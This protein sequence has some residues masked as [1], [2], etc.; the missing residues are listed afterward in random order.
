MI[1]TSEIR[2]LEQRLGREFRYAAQQALNDA[3]FEVRSGLGRGADKSFSGGA[4]RFTQRGFVVSKKGTKTDLSAIVEAKPIQAQYLKLPTFGGMRRKG[5][6]ATTASGIVIPGA[7]AK[8]TRTGS[9]SHTALKRALER[10]DVFSGTV[11]FSNGGS[12]RGVFRRPK[13]KGRVALEPLRVMA[14]FR[15]KE[16]EYRKQFF[17]IAGI[18]SAD[19][20]PAVR[21]SIERSM[22]EIDRFGRIRTTKERRAA[23]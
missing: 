17:D 14:L 20:T 8:R 7:A 13:R 23:S 5:D 9:L 2:R 4:T 15:K 22:R 1:S 3:A 10:P 6:Y 16:I 11:K 21:L 12:A 18:A 19:F